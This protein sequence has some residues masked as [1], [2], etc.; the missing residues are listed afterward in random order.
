MEGY[1]EVGVCSFRLRLF[2][3]QVWVGLVCSNLAR[4]ASDR[5]GFTRLGAAQLSVA[6]KLGLELIH[7]FKRYVEAG[8]FC[9]G[10][11]S[12]LA[13]LVLAKTIQG[14]FNP[15]QLKVIMDPI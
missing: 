4:P 11:R 13:R 5:L 12:S 15:T 10:C 8:E 7:L 6:Q 3:A 14:Q 9:F 1:T 2:S